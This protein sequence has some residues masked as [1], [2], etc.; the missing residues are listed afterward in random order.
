ML[1]FGL[2]ILTIV[3]YLKQGDFVGYLIRKVPPFEV[4]TLQSKL[5][6]ANILPSYVIRLDEVAFLDSSSIAHSERP[7]LDGL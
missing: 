3:V 5:C 1:T 6:L 4:R 7:I 2:D